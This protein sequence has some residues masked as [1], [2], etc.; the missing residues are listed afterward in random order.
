M[1]YCSNCG[2]EIQQETK[3]CP[4]CGANQ[5][6]RQVTLQSQPT[7]SVSTPKEK[8]LNVFSLIGFIVSIISIFLDFYSIP[9][10]LT[11]LIFSII[12]FVQVNEKNEKGRGFAITGMILG[13]LAILYGLSL[14]AL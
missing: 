2:K 6:I 9:V 7:Q 10:G 4:H 11:A 8:K 3:F 1:S 14:F 5:E 13:S 12:G